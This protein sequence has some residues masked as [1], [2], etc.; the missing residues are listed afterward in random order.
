MNASEPR[1][2][3]ATEAAE[4]GRT[5][6]HCAAFRAAIDFFRL[7]AGHGANASGEVA[8]ASAESSPASK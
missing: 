5:E 6:A 1:A 4:L 3:H 8:D 2:E 7:D